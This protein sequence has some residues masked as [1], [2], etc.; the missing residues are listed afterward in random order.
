MSLSPPPKDPAFESKR[1]DWIRCLGSNDQNSVMHQV[2]DIVWNAGAYRVVLEARRIA[3]KD[4]QGRVKLNG[5]THQ[6]LDRCFYQNQLVSIRR[7]MDSYPLTGD[8]G[9]FSLRSLLL[10]MKT[11]RAKFTRQNL[12]SAFEQVMDVDAARAAWHE[13]LGALPQ[14]ESSWTFNQDPDISEKL[15]QNI[16][17]LCSVTPAA[18]RPADVIAES[19]FVSLEA[20]LART[21]GICEQVNKFVAH[22]A[23][24]ESR[25]RIDADQAK[26]TFAQLWEAHEIICRIC[27][28]I[29]CFLLRQ[30][31]H[32]FLADGAGDPF[33]YIEE[34]LAT[35][36][37]IP[38]LRDAWTAYKKETE[39]WGDCALEWV[40]KPGCP[41]TSPPEGN[42]VQA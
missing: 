10:D 17:A 39:A 13:H 40:L 26:I 12:F 11:H 23:T 21:E 22:A 30:T 2:Y 41:D 32:S 36:E 1:K 15:H 24:P 35:R 5:L 29:D 16:D 25:A 7:L 42:L 33:R 4:E 28:F 3:S 34:P 19:I 9:V 38:V 20:K 37:L 14:E 8:R 31:N 6:L 27:Q 18:R